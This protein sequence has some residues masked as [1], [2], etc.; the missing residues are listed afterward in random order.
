M[1][2]RDAATTRR[3]GLSS[4]GLVVSCAIAEPCAR[5][6][7]SSCARRWSIADRSGGGEASRG[8]DFISLTSAAS[9]SDCARAAASSVRSEAEDVSSDW[10]RAAAAVSGTGAGAGGGGALVLDSTLAI[11]AARP[12]IAAV[13]A[14]GAGSGEP[15]FHPRNQA[16]PSTAPAGPAPA[17]D[18]AI[19]GNIADA[20]GRSAA[21]SGLGSGSAPAA[22]LVSP[23]TSVAS[24]SIVGPA[25][26]GRTDSAGGSVSSGLSSTITAFLVCNGPKPAGFGQSLGDTPLPLS[27]IRAATHGPASRTGHF[28]PATVLP[29]PAGPRR[30]G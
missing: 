4:A 12:S 2:S 27:A 19:T 22:F 20:A 11:R 16:T 21:G 26:L 25:R 24:R 5:V 28:H 30:R 23:E 15:A 7:C 9:F 17:N 10:R 3:S 8:A 18:A 13:S 6:V 29:L 14:G 1:S